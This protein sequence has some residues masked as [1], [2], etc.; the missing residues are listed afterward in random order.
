MEE[1]IRSSQ[2]HANAYWFVDGLME[3]GWGIV[4]LV[5]A[6]YFVLLQL[7]PSTQGIFI[8][9]FLFVFVV[10][11]GIRWLMVKQRER[12]TYPRTGYVELEHGW[13]DRRSLAIAVGFTVLL[14]VFMG[15]TILRGIQTLAWQ[16]AI[17]AAILAFIFC[18][19]G[20]RT[21][22]LRLYFLGGFCLLLGIFLAASGLGEFL[23]TAIL[24][25][26]TAVILLAF[27]IVTRS[28]YLHDTKAK[29]G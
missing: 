1:K 17:A 24:C 5:L 18:L 19:A 8:G 4:C 12:S 28:A 16:P 13:S 27:G 7:L 3:I 6:A 20:Y 2:A 21:K 14:L 22:L 15:L 11:F 25:L 23:G 9:L 26:V 10:A 29:T